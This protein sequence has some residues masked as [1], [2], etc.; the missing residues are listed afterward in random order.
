MVRLL[1]II[2]MKSKRKHNTVN[3]ANC[4]LKMASFFSFLVTNLE[5]GY[6]Y[7]VIAKIDYNTLSLFIYL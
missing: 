5:K 1:N 6:T 3:I 2:M 4:A 7:K